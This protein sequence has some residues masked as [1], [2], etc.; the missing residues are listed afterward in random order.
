MVDERRVEDRHR[1]HDDR[2]QQRGDGRPGQ[3]PARRQPSAARAKPITWLPESPMKTAAGLPRRRLNGRKPQQ[4][5]RDGEREHLHLRVRILRERVEREVGAGDR[6]QRRGQAVHVVQQVEGVR[7]ADE[8]ERRAIAVARIVLET[9]STRVPVAITSAA[10]ATWPP[11]LASGGSAWMSSASP[12]TKTMAQPPRIPSIAWSRSIAPVA[13][14]A[15]AGHDPR[16]DP[17]PAQRRRDLLGPAVALRRGDEAARRGPS[18][19]ARRGRARRRE[20]DEHRGGAHGAAL[21]AVPARA[22]SNEVLLSPCEW[23]GLPTALD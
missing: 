1:E 15:D 20:R 3:L 6:G 4:A 21:R 16:E 2:Q 14:G 8:P 5:K 10:A 13:R 23:G 12:T 11:S 9:I 19:G 22:K 17:D 18:A 7:H